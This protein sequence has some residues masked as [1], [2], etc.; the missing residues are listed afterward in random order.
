MKY[1]FIQD[2]SINHSAQRLC[3]IMGVSTSGY[4][5]WRA[6]EPSA[7]ENRDQQLLLL[8]RKSFNRSHGIYGAPRVYDD[9]KAENEAVSRKRIARLMRDNSLVAR[10]VRAF[11]RTTISDPLSLFAPNILQ[12]NFVAEDVNQRW[13]SDI[14]YVATDEGW[15]YLATVMDLYSRAIVGWAMNKHM[16]AMLIS[17]ALSMAIKNRRP[18]SGLVLHSDRGTQY[19]STAY[20]NLLATHGI[21]CSMS[22]TGNGYDNAAMESFFHSLKTE[23]VNHYKYETR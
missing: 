15:L 19:C 18:L 14:T 2:E 4:Y 6:R 1:A 12:Q 11:K 21:R 9:L 17:S 16:D 5:D 8:I 3:R 7:H 23:W 10:C 22:A 20:Q 13:V